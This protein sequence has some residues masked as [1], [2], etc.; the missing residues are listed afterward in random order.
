M[1]GSTQEADAPLIR[2]T[3]V[4]KTNNTHVTHDST[5]HQKPRKNPPPQKKERKEIEYIIIKQ[6][7]LTVN[8]CR[9]LQLYCR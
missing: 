7:L 4:M 6:L 2:A 5:K 9:L 3:Q 8:V 1:T